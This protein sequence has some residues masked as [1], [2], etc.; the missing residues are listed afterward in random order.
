[1]E[2]MGPLYSS[3]QKKKRRKRY[4]S[5]SSRFMNGRKRGA[6]LVWYNEKGPKVRSNNDALN[7]LEKSIYHTSGVNKEQDGLCPAGRVKKKKN[8]GLR[9]EP[10]GREI[11]IEHPE[12]GIHHITRKGTVQSFSTRLFLAK[13]RGENP[14]G[15]GNVKKSKEKAPVRS[16]RK[17]GSFAEETKNQAVA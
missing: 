17:W 2:G 9:T 1:M 16:E 7:P 3:D 10:E 12:K 8:L 15:V 11:S 4:D 5:F 13:G 6:P 14:S